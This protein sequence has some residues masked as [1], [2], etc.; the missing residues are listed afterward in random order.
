MTHSKK[1]KPI[2]ANSEV[3]Q[4]WRLGYKDFKAVIITMLNEIKESILVISEN[5]EKSQQR[6]SIKKNQMEHKKQESS[7]KLRKIL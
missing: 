5:T 7:Y 4:I 6:N 1:N 3:A 2:E